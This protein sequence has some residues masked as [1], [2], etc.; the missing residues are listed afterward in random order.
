MGFNSGFKVLITHGARKTYGTK[1]V[2]LHAFFTSATIYGDDRSASRPNKL[3][4]RNDPPTANRWRTVGS[5][6]DLDCGVRRKSLISPR[7]KPQTIKYTD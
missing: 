1:V 6:F 2:Q 7:V 4:P 3:P 5:D